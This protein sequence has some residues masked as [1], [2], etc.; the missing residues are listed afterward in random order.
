MIIT[1]QINK[2]EV[3]LGINNKFLESLFIHPWRAFF[4][5]YI[6]VSL[7]IF[8]ISNI[9]KVINFSL[10]GLPVC[11]VSIFIAT[12]YHKNSCYKLVFNIVSKKVSFYR[13][14]T[15]NCTEANAN[16][17]RI[18]IGREV[19]LIAN[20]INYKIFTDILHDV[21]SYLPPDTT[22]MYKGLFG[23]HFEKELKILNK[24]LTP[25]KNF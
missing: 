6:F 15:K 19:I 22:I 12:I 24:P 23:K 14:F 2:D 16:K 5:S 11:M 13:M 4:I 9:D 8:F 3:H 17:I 25:G 7:L 10:I 21:V 1:S 18:E 20:Q